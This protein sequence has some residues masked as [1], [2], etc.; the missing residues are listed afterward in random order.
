[1]KNHREKYY[2]TDLQIIFDNPF[3]RTEIRGELLA[4]IQSAT[5]STSSTH[6]TLPLNSALQRDSIPPSHICR[7]VPAGTEI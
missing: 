5:Y 3:G 6:G 7:E 1:M 4:S 2:G